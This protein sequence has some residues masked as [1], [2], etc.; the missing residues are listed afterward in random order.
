MGVFF[1]SSLAFAIRIEDTEIG[2]LTN[3]VS[4]D[5]LPD[6]IRIQLDGQLNFELPKSRKVGLLLPCLV[7]KKAPT[8]QARLSINTLL[9]QVQNA[10]FHL[11]QV[12]R[13]S[14]NQLNRQQ[15]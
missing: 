3:V 5:K 2:R 1:S 6:S 14:F 4:I 12:C 10:L 9:M 8:K 13:Y 11:T 7:C 15:H